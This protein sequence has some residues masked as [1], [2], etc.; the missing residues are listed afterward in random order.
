MEGMDSAELIRP[1]IEKD[2]IRMIGAIF[3]EDYPPCIEKDSVLA[4]YFQKVSVG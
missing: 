3:I 4:H 2:D 1:F